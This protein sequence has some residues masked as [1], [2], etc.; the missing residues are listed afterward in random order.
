M[1]I[2]DGNYTGCKHGDGTATTATTP[3]CPVCMGSGV[4]AVVCGGCGREIDPDTCGCGEGKH[5]NNSD[6]GHPFVPMGCN[7]ARMTP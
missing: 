6:T 5:S 7:C 1:E 2:G 3:D 4:E